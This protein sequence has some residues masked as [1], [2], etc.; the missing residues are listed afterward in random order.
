MFDFFVIDSLRFW[1]TIA[2]P[3]KNKIKH[4]ETA[5]TASITEKF[6]VIRYSKPKHPSIPNK[7]QK[8]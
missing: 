2:C 3:I 5:N 7:Y 8:A 4:T 1:I 6:E